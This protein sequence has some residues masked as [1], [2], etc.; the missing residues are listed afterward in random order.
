[1]LGS[2][3][4]YD[5]ADA[6]QQCDDCNGWFDL[7][8]MAGNSCKACRA[9]C[10]KIRAYAEPAPGYSWDDWAEIAD[11]AGE[12][13][14]GCGFDCDGKCNGMRNHAC[15]WD[16]EKACC[17]GCADN[18][19][20]LSR[21]PIEAVAA[22]EALFD[23]DDGFW[24]PDG[25]ALPQAWRSR[26]CIGYYCGDPGEADPNAWNAWRDLINGR[27]ENSVGQVR[28]LL[29]DAGMLKTGQLVTIN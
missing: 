19:G 24:R 1:M 17:A 8:D 25:C 2:D 18:T 28:A 10:I 12:I 20:Y 15:S 13:D 4:C 22:I 3:I 5:C 26:I 6:R 7:D 9:D 23:D 29:R 27:G 21:V 16:T 11:L 14:F